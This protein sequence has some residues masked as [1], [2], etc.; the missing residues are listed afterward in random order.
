MIALTEKGFNTVL[1]WENPNIRQYVSI[2]PTS[3]YT[4]E[5][6]PDL[7][8]VML[9]YSQQIL[10]EKITLKDTFNCTLLEVKKIEGLGT[11]IDVILVNGTLREGDKI[12]LLGF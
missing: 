11:T 9:K 12:C 5:G 2:V 7:F 3:G 4:G 10:K 8:S 1:Y 6:V